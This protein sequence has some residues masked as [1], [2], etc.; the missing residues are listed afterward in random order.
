MV[1]YYLSGESGHELLSEIA[2]SSQSSHNPQV[3]SEEDFYADILLDDIVKL[4]DP[5]DSGNTLIDVPRLQSESTT[6]RV[7]PLPIMVDKQ[8]QSLL[9]KLPLQNDIGEENNISMSSC[10]IGIY[11]IKSINRARW[12]AV[13][14]VLV[15]I[16]V[17]VFYL[18]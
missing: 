16:A 14:W 18:V 9:Q 8:M 10:F 6:T 7:L 3:R 17:L 13:A 2:E 11:S 1:D 4:D 5:A 15:M 12:D